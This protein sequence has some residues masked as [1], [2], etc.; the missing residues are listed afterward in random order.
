MTIA[1]V[2]TDHS[3]RHLP[4]RI[5]KRLHT[6]NNVRVNDEL[7]WSEMDRAQ[8]TDFANMATNLLAK[9]PDILLRTIVVYKQNVRQHIR[10][11]QNKLYNYMI[12]LSLTPDMSKADEV[13][14]VPDPKSIKVQSGNSL[15]DYLQTTL[16]FERE[17]ATVLTTKP[18]DSKSHFGVQFA[19]MLAGLVQAHFE[20]GNSDYWAILSPKISTRRL[21]FPK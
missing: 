6:K 13:L 21:Y 19:D 11:D 3:K 7:K 10:D 16:W 14:F 4:K 18:M 15:H 8:R 17:A 1:S 20:D 5:I 2:V 12:Q 9:H